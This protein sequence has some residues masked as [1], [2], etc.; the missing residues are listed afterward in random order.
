ME[1]YF[2]PE[3][4][5]LYKN[6]II[7]LLGLCSVTSFAQTLPLDSILYRIEKN[8]PM[9]MMY[10]EQIHAVNNY[11]QGAK[12]WMPPTIS[13]GL[14]QT[15]YS[16]VAEG[17]LMVSAEQMIPNPVKQD[18]NYNFMLGM[19]PVEAEEKK[20]KRNEM[21]AMA[22]QSYYE[23]VVLK[24]K[25]EIVQQNDSLLDY[26]VHIAKLRLTYNKEKLNN[27]Y[28][29]QADLFELR[30]M[31]L[32]L[33]GEMRMKAVELNTLM[34]RDKNMVFDID[35]TVSLHNYD[36]TLPDTIQLLSSRSDFKRYDASISL[37]KLQQEY[38]KSKRLPDFGIS[39]SHMQSLGMMPSQYSIMGMIS[40]P[41]SPWASRE[42]DANIEGLKNT[43]NAM[44]YQKQAL[45]NQSSG[46][47]ASLQAQM[48]IARQQ[49]TNYRE[50]IIPSYDKSYE[51]SM[52]AYQQNTEDL[53]VVLE[54][55]KMYRM[56]RMNAL[57]VLAN[58]LQLEV[59][60][61]K[62]MEIR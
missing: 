8:N 54:A 26:I 35:S 10:E 42:Y 17:M 32:M 33:Q 12:S 1:K 58:V 28:K 27:I 36:S 39:L 11:A 7:V 61:E 2:Y 46:M 3:E 53:F 16:M 44:S 50:N 41:L 43:M 22:K 52:N 6:I 15:P 18:A 47:I 51:S 21:F 14:W 37:L 31:D 5:K 9:L 25:H 19:I 29:A 48:R 49:L 13:A 24:K 62:E 23:W 59:Q 56:A 57:D 45:L 38:E 34:S 60:Y 20:A 4:M 55:L 40:L 30:N